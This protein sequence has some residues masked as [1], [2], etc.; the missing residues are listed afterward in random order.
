MSQRPVVSIVVPSFNTERYVERCIN[1]CLS[2]STSLKYEVVLMDDKSTDST[3][4][5]VRDLYGNEE[6]LAIGQNKENIG[7]GM[8]R[9]KCIQQA[10]G[11]YIFLID[12][13]DY[14]HPKTIDI[15]YYSMQLLPNIPIVFCDYTYVDDRE[16]KS[17]PISAVDRPI[18]CGQL[19][20]K[21]LFAQYG[22]YSDKRVGEEREFRERLNANG[23]EML[24]LPL[25]LYRYRQRV[26]SITSEFESSRT[27]DVIGGK[28]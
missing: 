14:I 9:N 27:Y 13:D 17:S 25:P 7:V 6:L 21:F 12:S 22:L 19:I 1:S 23:V 8:T 24:H 20:S 28:E 16:Q 10:K 3:Y 15:M 2:Q 11:R 4:E 18:A 26:M 5:I